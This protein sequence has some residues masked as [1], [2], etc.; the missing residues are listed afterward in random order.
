MKHQRRFETANSTQRLQIEALMKSLRRYVDLLDVDIDTEER[1]AQTDRMDDPNYPQ[2]ARHFCARR[3][4]L[5][6]TLE[7]LQARLEAQQ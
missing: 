1:S 2:L 7:L 3:H 6:A 4:N 5:V